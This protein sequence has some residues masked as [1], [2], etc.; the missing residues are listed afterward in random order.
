MTKVIRPVAENALRRAFFYNGG[1]LW[2]RPLRAMMKAA[3]FRLSLGLPNRDDVVAVWGNSPTS[4][5]GRWIAQKRGVAVLH[6]EDAFL[7]SV[8]PGRAGEP[9]LGIMIDASGVHFDPNQPSDLEAL[10]KTQ[11]LD[12]AALLAR[13]EAGLDRLRRGHLSKYNA[14]DPEA[15]PDE[16]GYVLVIDQTSGDASVSASGGDRAAFLEML[17]TARAEH[18]DRK[19]L[20]RTHPETSQGLRAGHFLQSDCDTHMELFDAPAS[21]WA[22]LEGAHAVYCFSSQMGMEAIFVGHRPQVFGQPIYVGWGLTEDRGGA[23]VARRGRPLT[24]AQL[25]AAVMLEFPKWYDPFEDRLCSFER[26]VDILE[27]KVRCWREDHRGWVASGMR[28]WK[29]SPLQKF[30]GR[31]RKLRFVDPPSD[32]V[33][34][35]STSGMRSMVW[36]GNASKASKQ[37]RV[38]DG[39]LRSRGLGA[40][41]TPPLSLVADDLGIYYDPTGPSRLEKLVAASIDLQ[42]IARARAEELRLAICKAGLSKYNLGGVG[43]SAESSHTTR[44][45]VPGQVEDDESIRLGAGSVRTNRAL[46]LAARKH[47]PNATLVYKPHPDVEAGLRRGQIED[48]ETLADLVLTRGDPIAAIETCD[49][50]FTMTSTLGFEALLRG[51][52]VT[53]LGQPFYA[54]WGLTEDHGP[55]IPRR[56]ARPDLTAF[57]HAV[58]IDYPRY[59]DP[60]TGL[61]CPVEVALSRLSKGEIPKPGPLNRAI[62]KLQG[63]FASYAYLWR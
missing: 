37:V 1:F 8:L 61:P 40:E 3:G 52:P 43:L 47:F 2:Q 25:F 19:I 34:I 10:L 39:F 12:D 11:P 24:V 27:A 38:E 45:L 53:C 62:S 7:R 28:L 56:N 50:I 35:A 42:P 20:I 30:F 4:H 9:P 57:I 60:V 41:L 63:Q 49:R 59:V 23:P 46:L 31:Y 22:L 29:R 55:G 36:A 26:A 16:T 51:K 48:A 58:L 5:R 54:G 13:A 6:V 44:V 14:F 21:P 33:R 15:G 18:P 17:R 32:A